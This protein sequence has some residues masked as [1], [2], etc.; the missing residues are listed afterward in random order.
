MD[1]VSGT[2]AISGEPGLFRCE[3]QDRR[4]PAHQAI[5]G[6]VEHGPRRAPPRIVDTV[7]VE[8]VLADVEVKRRQVDRAEIMQ[9]GEHRVE[10]IGVDRATHDLIELAEAVQYPAL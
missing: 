9:R 8:P 1:A 2:V 6:P 3:A 10:I 5:E 7:A 4:Q